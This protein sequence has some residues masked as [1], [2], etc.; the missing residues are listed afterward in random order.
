MSKR[1]YRTLDKL[2]ENYFREHPEEIEI[3]LKEIF[4]L[5]AEDGDSAVLLASLRVIAKV[6]GISALAK[7]TGMTRQGLQKALSSKG[8]PR[9]DNVNAIIRSI[10]FQLV[11]QRRV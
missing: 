11:P 1:N 5:Y 2:E 10:G 8:N 7:E 6:K 3:Y 9:L 4:E